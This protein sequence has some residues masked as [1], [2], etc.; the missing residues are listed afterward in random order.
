MIERLC[1]LVT[2]LI[3]IST[4]LY[5]RPFESELQPPPAFRV[6][7]YIRFVAESIVCLIS[8]FFIFV[9]QFTEVK[10]QGLAGL[11]GGLVSHFVLGFQVYI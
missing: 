8:F 10:A 9:E 5:L 1:F 2:H 3:C 4:A 11:I 6:V 7:D